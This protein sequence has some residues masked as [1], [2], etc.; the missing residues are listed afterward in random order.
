MPR[1]AEVGEDI[2]LK[3]QAPQLSSSFSAL[4]PCWLANLIY[5]FLIRSFCFC[6][7]SG[8]DEMLALEK[9]V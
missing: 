7:S 8:E 6:R 1:H 5:I 3:D 2:S 9:S 4:N